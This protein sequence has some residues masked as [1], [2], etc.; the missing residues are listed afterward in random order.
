MTTKQQILN[1]IDVVGFRETVSN[2]RKDPGLAK[3]RFRATNRWVNGGQ[4]R[5]TIHDFYGA[6][7]NIEHLR[8]FRLEADEPPLLLGEDKGANPVEYV[9]TALSACLTSSLVYHAAAQGVEIDEV[10]SELEGELDLRGFLGLSDKVRNGYENIRI[11]F[12]IKSDA[13]QAKLDELV[14]LAQARSPVFDIVT[15]PVPVTVTAQ[16]VKGGLH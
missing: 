11:T 16:K 3:S 8:D 12:R 15:H 6:R 7:K 5:V 14:Q 13:P 2:I 1:G 10:E 9:L 4:S